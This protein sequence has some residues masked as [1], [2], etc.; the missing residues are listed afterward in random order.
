MIAPALALA[1]LLA[2]AAPATVA[3]GFTPQG[4]DL[5]AERHAAAVAALDRDHGPSAVVPMATLRELADQVPDR[6][7]GIQALGRLLDDPRADP[8]LRALAR[9]R[10]AREER[11]RGNLQRAAIQVGRLGAVTRWLVIGPF[12]D[13]GRRALDRVEPPE[14]DLDPRARLT[15]K[16]REVAWR[17]LPPEA[18]VDGEVALGL[19]LRPAEE[20]AAYALAVVD[21]PRDQPAR[22]WFG[23]SG[24]SKVWVNGA[25]ALEDRIDH[26]GRFDQHGA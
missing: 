9:L 17:P 12:D 11:A 15:G 26:P 13:E 24:R 4:R 19:A 1:A 20:V 25:L 3:S 6:T 7:R 16:G 21:S 10:L 5:A 18:V 14:R 8:E 22:L 2:A 23:A